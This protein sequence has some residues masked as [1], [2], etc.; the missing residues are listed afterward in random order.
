VLC[1]V[2]VCNSWAGLRLLAAALVLALSA[3]LLRRCR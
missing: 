2:L 1:R 3:T